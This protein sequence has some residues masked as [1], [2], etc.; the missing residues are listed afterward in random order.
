[1]FLPVLGA[2]EDDDGEPAPLE[3]VRLRAP[4]GAGRFLPAMLLRGGLVASTGL[5][6]A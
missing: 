6:A 2:A 4:P 1:M 5:I 3:P